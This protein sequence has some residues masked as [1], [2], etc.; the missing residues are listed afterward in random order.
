MADHITGGEIY[1]S[2]VGITGGQYQYSITLKLF[3]VCN[4]TRQF[5][6]PTYVSF[7]DKGTNARIKDVSVNLARTELIS[8]TPNSPCITNPPTVCYR[9]GYYNFNITL[10]ASTNGYILS[11]QVIYRVDGMKNLIAGYDRVGA[12]YTAEIP[13]NASGTDAPANNSAQ[14]T[15]DDLVVICA[16]NSFSYSFAA[17]DDDGDQLSYSFCNAYRETSGGFN[18]GGSP[19][20]PPPYT[21]VPYGQGYDGSLPLGT[22]VSINPAT[23]LL[24]GTAPAEGIYVIE[25]CVQEIRNNIVIATQR[26]DIQI[27]IT[28]CS[29]VAAKLQPDYSLCGDTKSITLSN[30]SNSPRIKTY[31]WQFTNAAG[32]TIYTT[33]QH[34]ANY[35]FPDTGLYKVKLIINKSDECSDSA[36]STVRVYP[37]FIPGFRFN[38]ICVNKP[39]QFTDTS[40]SVYGNVNYRNWDF[41]DQSSIADVSGLQN[42]VYTYTVAGAKNVR[43]I[44]SDSKGCMD[45]VFGNVTIVDKP[46]LTTAFK[47]TLICKGDSMR[48]AVTGSGNYTWSPN[49][50]ITAPNIASPVVSPPVTT[51]YY[52]ELDDNGCINHDSV[53]I[54]VVDHVS[55]QAMAD[56]TVCSGDTIT[57]N[58]VSDGLKYTWTPASSL[59]NA[60]EKAPVAVPSSTT[61]Y[62]VLAETGSCSAK[63]NIIVSTVNYPVAVAGNDTMICFQT[64]ATLHGITDGSSFTWSPQTALQYANTLD[65]VAYP[66]ATTAYVLSAYDTK[67]CPKPGRDTTI[68]TVLPAIN[69]FAGRDTAVVAGQTLQLNATGGLKYEWF[70]P[71]G[72]SDANIAKPVAMYSTA[73]EGIRYKVYVYNEAGCVDTASITVKVFGTLPTV[74]VPTA[75]TPNDDG[76]NDVLRPIA[77]GM[78]RVEMFNVYNRWGQL[79]F[80]TAVNGKGW[81][82]TVNGQKQSAGTYIWIVKAV[83]YTGA[84]YIQKGTVVLIR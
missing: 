8:L 12:T 10:P 33:T 83:D 67:G 30:L 80:S 31:D 54:H 69:A 22:N 84:L 35:A 36:T 58:I 55:L 7:F 50:F 81:D 26:K 40:V 51:T 20:E 27:T 13:G 29:I 75:F 61:T 45:T 77:A 60:G 23:G 28:S 25:V 79:L 42:P 62:E 17:K 68:V 57:L 5:P 14:F 76:R 15:G 65:P 56:T 43:L 72:L 71:T 41:G 49:T 52:V 32:T 66:A 6:D 47:D 82:G 37:G 63:E 53:T 18:E 16:N 24:T 11:S 74:F 64:P 3:M 4:T 1:Y 9:V 19:T 39:T 70:P 38:G 78:Q 48:L 2:F 44:V 46:P 34:Q 73:T 21:S 59:S